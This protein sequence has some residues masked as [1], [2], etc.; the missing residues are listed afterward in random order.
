MTATFA[1]APTLLADVSGPVAVGE[2]S[3]SVGHEEVVPVMR[4]TLATDLANVKAPSGKKFIVSA[5]LTKLETTT[6]GSQTTTNCVVSL[7][8]ID[9]KDG[10]LRGVVQGTSASSGTSD[11]ALNA[12]LVAA[13]IHGAARG[14]SAAVAQ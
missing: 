7:A 8:L 5:S 11:G 4:S 2:V 13:A 3:T 12:G 14:V 9:A 10:T 1:V 6:N